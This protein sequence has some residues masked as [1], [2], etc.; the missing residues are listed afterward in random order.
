MSEGQSEPQ[1]AAQPEFQPASILSLAYLGDAVFEL[2][3]RDMLTRENGL[4]HNG[5]NKLAKNYVPAIKQAAM[6]HKIFPYL[7]ED[8]QS[9]IKRGRNLNTSSRAKNAPAA[10]YRH[11]TGLET[12]FGYLYAAKQ[13]DRLK[14]IFDLCVTEQ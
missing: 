8:E 13:Y 1:S 10:D 7:T 3:V 4:T 12:L 5:Y 9:V 11:A 14:E 2:C 6:Y